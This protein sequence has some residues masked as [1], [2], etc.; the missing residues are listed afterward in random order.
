VRPAPGS[1]DGPYLDLI[2]DGVLDLGDTY[3]AQH[4]RL[5][6]AALVQTAM[7]ASQR[8]HAYHQ[9]HALL[10]ESVS[11]LGHQARRAGGRKDRSDPSYHRL[12][13]KAW[14]EAL[15]VVAERPALCPAD[16]AVLI[17]A[18]RRVIADADAALS[19]DERAVLNAACTLAEQYG[20]VRPACPRR[21][22]QKLA[23]IPD[24]RAR[25]ALRS[26]HER[27]VLPVAR[28]GRTALVKEDRRATLRRLPSHAV[29]DSLTHTSPEEKTYGLAHQ[30]YGSAHE[31]Y[32]SDDRPSTEPAPQEDTVSPENTAKIV[33]AAVGAAISPQLTAMRAELD[34]LRARLPEPESATVRHLRPVTSDD[35][36]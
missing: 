18:V 26:L 13:T 25:A 7:S 32:G 8:G 15:E 33:A 12:L 4:D 22:V 24:G 2:R 14:D 5:V 34:Q 20:T 30:A 36:S 9:W 19:D 11:R 16:R 17:D 28:K 21:E 29:L 6:Y 3:G 23:G 27:G 1:L 35:L 31:T 10:G